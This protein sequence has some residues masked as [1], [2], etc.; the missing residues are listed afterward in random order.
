MASAPR[1]LVCYVPQQAGANIAV[2]LPCRAPDR[3]RASLKVTRFSRFLGSDLLDACKVT[4]QALDR[5]L[6]LHVMR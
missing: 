2:P 3:P 6:S 1:W 4:K 5:R